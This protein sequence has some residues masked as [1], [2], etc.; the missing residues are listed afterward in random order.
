ML[1]T[2]EERKKGKKAHVSLCANPS[3]FIGHEMVNDD[4]THTH[5]KGTTNKA[6]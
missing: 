6:A 2:S 4:K 3:P 5:K 1:Y